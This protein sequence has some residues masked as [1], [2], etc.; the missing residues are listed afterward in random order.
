MADKPHNG[1]NI[2]VSPSSAM[3]TNISNLGSIKAERHESLM[4]YPPVAAR[5]MQNSHQHP[6][7]FSSYAAAAPMVAE[8]GVSFDP[9][10]RNH[11]FPSIQYQM[12]LVNVPNEDITNM[13]QMTAD[14]NTS[15]VDDYKNSIEELFAKV[16]KLEQGVN[17]VEQFYQNAK[18]KKPNTSKCALTIKGKE[19]EKHNPSMK[20]LQQ[21]PSRRE[22]AVANRMQELMHHFGSIFREADVE[23]LGLHDYYQIIDRPMDFSTIENRM[24]AKD[25][26]GYKHIRE[27]CSDERIREEEETGAQMNIQLAQ[28]AAHAKLARDISNELYNIDLH[29]EELR[30][31]VVEKCRHISTL[32]KRNLGIALTKL[33]PEDLKKALDIIAQ[34]NPNF[35]VT[36][37]EVEL[38]IS[39]QGVL[40][41]ESKIDDEND[42][43]AD[44]HDNNIVSKRK[45]QICN[46]LAKSAKRRK[47]N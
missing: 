16:D 41:G 40:K 10:P 43:S 38:D 6:P 21:E 2:S 34:T 29:L 25:G 8:F 31:M 4:V 47:S 18:P 14:G 19:K 46:A 7:P 26:T 33:C 5:A 22:A 32:E 24:G 35:Q 9:L 37:Q 17:E 36:A 11:E 45:Q 28:E 1:A 20:N 12:D 3:K 23:G 44:E 30:E 13:G 42:T 27:I 15:Q 39:A